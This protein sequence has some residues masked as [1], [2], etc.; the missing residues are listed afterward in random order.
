M[1]SRLYERYLILLFSCNSASLTI[2]LVG[3]MRKNSTIIE[4]IGRENRVEISMEKDKDM[5]SSCQ[6]VRVRIK[7]P[8]RTSGSQLFRTSAIIHAERSF[9]EQNW[10]KDCT[11]CYR[12]GKVKSDMESQQ[13]F[14]NSKIRTN[15]WVYY[16]T[17]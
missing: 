5:V 4:K 17:H 7:F 16:M 13:H 12:Y 9:Y 14:H 10:G 15:N 11:G 6:Y 3:K 1:Q 2:L 8:I